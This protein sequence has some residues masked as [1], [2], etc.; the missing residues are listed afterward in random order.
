[1]TFRFVIKEIT[2][3]DQWK[4]N[5]AVMNAHV[6]GTICT[7]SPYR[8]RECYGPSPSCEDQVQSLEYE[9]VC[10]P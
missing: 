5:H 1:L 7:F 9:A 8:C 10:R 2:N 6:F 3:G 4:E